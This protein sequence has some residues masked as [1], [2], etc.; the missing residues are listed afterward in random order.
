VKKKRRGGPLLP[1]GMSVMQYDETGVPGITT[2]GMVRLV[3]EEMTS[4][5]ESDS[6][7]IDIQMC[8][9]VKVILKLRHA[10]ER[11]LKDTDRYLRE[12]ELY[13]KEN[14]EKEQ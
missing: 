11:C 8:D 7:L 14:Q 3:V 13:G 2:H 9:Q 10:L 6:A 5:I 4:F 1:W 12:M